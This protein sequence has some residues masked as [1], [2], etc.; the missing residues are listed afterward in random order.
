M[1]LVN[2]FKETVLP[3]T[4]A[5]NSIYYVTDADPN[6]LQ[7]YVTSTGGVARRLPT[8]ADIQALINTAIAGVA[9]GTVVADI[10]AR[11][12]QAGLTVGKQTLVLD[13]TGDGT[14]LSGAAT[15]VVRSTGPVVWAKISEAESLDVIQTWAALTGKPT[16][17]VAAIDAAVTA[18]HTHANKT[19]LD[20]IGETGGLITYNGQPVN[21]NW[22][23]TTW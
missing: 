4:P 21:L 1:A 16:S 6:Y 3:G 12:A 2:F 11:N 13:A 14:V 5:A 8:V 20:L 10:T 22:S 7:L 23:T 15:Y 17:S 9:A 19:Q 18:S